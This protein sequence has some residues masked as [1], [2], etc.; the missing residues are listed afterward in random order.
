MKKTATKNGIEA[1]TDLKIGDLV[2]VRG[3]T[4]GV[5]MCVEHF[6]QVPCRALDPSIAAAYSQP[7]APYK[8]PVG[9]VWRSRV[10]TRVVCRDVFEADTLRKITPAGAAA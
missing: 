9:C 8:G 5:K 1:A 2:E 6:Q 3:D 4:T 10:D 7:L